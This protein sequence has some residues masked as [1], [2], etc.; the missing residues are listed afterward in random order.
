VNT[1]GDPTTPWTVYHLD[2]TDDGTNGTP[3]H[4]GCPCLGDQPLLGI[5]QDNLYI[6]TNEFSILG[7]EFNGTQLYAIAKADLVALT[8]AHFVMFENLMIAGS[9][10]ASVQPALTNSDSP[11]E[12]FLSSLDPA[13]TTDNRIGV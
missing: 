9:P 7:P 4:P 8:T 6:S 2:A 5:D 3:S 10:A 12:Y 1:S 11:A 13:G